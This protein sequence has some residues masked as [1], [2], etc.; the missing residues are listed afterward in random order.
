MDFVSVQLR[1]R[2]SN[3]A[4][5]EKPEIISKGFVYVRESGELLAGAEQIIRE[6]VARG[7]AGELADARGERVVGILLLRNQAAADG[8]RVGDRRL[9]PIAS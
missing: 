3:G 7:G 4:L 9:I 5:T 6:A 2:A 1:V 8:F